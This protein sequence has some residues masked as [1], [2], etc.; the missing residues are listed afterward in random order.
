MTRVLRADQIAS[1]DPLPP[2][3]G[4]FNPQHPLGY[5]PIAGSI[6]YTL[7]PGLDHDRARRL[8]GD[9]E[10]LR[11]VHRPHRLG[12]ALDD[13]LPRHEPRLA[14]KRSRARRHH[15][16]VRR[17]DRH[18]S[19]SAAA[20]SSTARCS[21][22]SGGRASRGISPA[23]ACARGTRSGATPYADLVIENSYVDISAQRDHRGRLAR[24]RPTAASRSAIRARTIGDEIDATVAHARSSAGRPA[25]RLRAR[26]LAG[27]R[28]DLGRVPPPRPLRDAVRQRPAAD[29][30][31]PRLRRELRDGDV[32]P[33]LRGQRRAAWSRSTST[34]APAA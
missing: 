15:D 5:V 29:R 24:S 3:D 17:A 6:G 10:D 14:R 9:A 25:P 8:G 18:R 7:D 28:P 33:H 1:V 16:R 31:R 30:S 19:T 32:E 12:R 13:P 27:R 4:P 34:R 22:R 2:E 20:A 26:R 21:A 11:G 23:I